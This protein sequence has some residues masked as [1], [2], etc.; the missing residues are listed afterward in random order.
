MKNP[1]YRFYFPRNFTRDNYAL[2]AGGTVHAMQGFCYTETYT[3]V[4]G[5]EFRTDWNSTQAVQGI[6]YNAAKEPI[7]Y[8]GYTHNLSNNVVTCPAGTA[9]IRANWDMDKI[10]T[11]YI[12]SVDGTNNWLTT[13]RCYPN[14]K[15]DITIEI[16]RESG[17]QFYRKKWGGKLTFYGADYDYLLTGGVHRVNYLLL[18]ASTNGGKTWVNYH[19]SQFTLTD[20]TVDMDNKTIEVQPETYDDYTNI[21]AGMEKEYNLIDLLP[22]FCPV[23]LSK[24]PLIQLYVPGDSVISCFLGGTAWEQDANE[25]TNEKT[26]RKTYKFG[27]CNILKEI[28]LTGT[29]TPADLGLYTGRMAQGSTPNEFNGKM[30]SESRDYYLYISQGLTLDKEDDYTW[31]LIGDVLV[32]YRRASDDVAL[33]RYT[34]TGS[35]SPFDNLEFTLS[36]VEG[37]GATGDL[38]ADM[39]SYNVYGRYLVDV[40][41]INGTAAV[42]IPAEDITDNSRHYKYAFAYAQDVCYL[43]YNYTE[44]P[45]PY[46]LADNGKYFAPPAD[47]QKYYPIAQSTWRYGSLWFAFDRND[48]GLEV[49]GRKRY[50]LR[51]AYKLSS[52]INVLL[53][54]IAPDVV[55]DDKEEYSRFLYSEQN[56]LNK[57]PN[58]RLI[59]SPKSN[60]T[61]GEYQTP[62]QKA[63]IT[64][65]N[66]LTALANLYRLYWYVE[67]G[68]LKLEHV[69][70]FR[71]GG[72][73][74][75]QM[76][77]GTD[78]TTLYNIRNGKP[79]DY[80]QNQ[81][82]YDKEQM[83]S[84]YEFAFMDECSDI[85]DGKPINVL[86]EFVDESKKEDVNVPN[87]TTDIDYMLLVP[88]EI[89]EDGFV[90]LA[91]HPAEAITDNLD[92]PF[93]G[94]GIEV[95][96][97]YDYTVP[98]INVDALARGKAA[99]LVLTA[100]GG[101]KGIVSWF[102]D[103]GKKLTVP[104]VTF[105]AD[106]TTRA[107]SV[108]IPDTAAQLAIYAWGLVQARVQSLTVGSMWQ[109]PFTRIYYDGAEH[110]AQNGEL[111]MPYLQ[112]W[113]WVYDMPAS[114]LE[115]NGQYTGAQ[116]I[117][118]LKKQ[119]LKY[120]AGLNPDTAK[121]V[122][123]SVGSGVITK[124]SVTLGSL[125]GNVT[126]QH[127]TD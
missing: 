109:L 108:T 114:A 101:A 62:A 123:T 77:I 36:P 30:W 65:A 59:I 39:S 45:T 6:F 32:E 11:A 29:G 80:T 126:L 18:Q 112:P 24:R 74:D 68:K 103:K 47:G 46:G 7:G 63:P 9:Y 99:T 26:L 125:T 41:S 1:L 89:S 95:G 122:K 86:S 37:T 2:F 5:R 91:A 92:Y 55:H 49:P 22:E 54:K 106:G 4:T 42:K 3:A 28:Q 58:A 66:V 14:Y 124:I 38:R 21:L 51:D 90:L 85:F 48:A 93:E 44:T 73:Y 71:R 64:L 107:L 120:P 12:G 121:L 84:R 87:I 110:L 16:E 15:D 8:W 100:S 104:D 61:N 40:E 23:E 10:N 17:Q 105:W 27:L 69:E 113:C 127:D 78:L 34:R 115:I 81:Y 116:S 60:I 79:C 96:G 111:A 31:E 76:Q 72:T 82:S 43:S 53:K 35:T 75:A 57:A 13:R 19:K 20:C 83:P 117:R 67:D 50:I 33:W 119:S 88:N 98:R 56:P 52:V 94:Y 25:T 70:W 102:D 97:N 118:R